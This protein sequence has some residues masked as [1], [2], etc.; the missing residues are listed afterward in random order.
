MRKVLLCTFLFVSLFS[1]SA[2]A[3]I[4]LNKDSSLVF[5]GYADAYYAYYTDSVGTANFQKFPTVSPRSNSFGLNI[6]MFNLKYNA[7]KVHATIGIHYGDIPLSTWSSAYNFIQ[8]AYA[9]VRL[10]KK[11]WLDAG[12]FRTHTGAEGLMPKENITSSVT[13]ATY[14]EP[15]YEAGMRLSIKP[16]DKF[17]LDLYVLNGYN[18]YEENNNK[19][20]VG[21]LATYAFSDHFNIGYSDYFG[22]DAVS[23]SAVSKFRTFNNLFVNYEK[24]KWKIQLAADLITQKHSDT[25]SIKTAQ[26]ADGFATVRYKAC[27]KT[28]VYARGEF[29]KDDSGFLGGSFTDNKNKTTG[30]KL[31]GI[32]AG[33]EYRPTDQAYIRLEARKLQCN[34]AEEIFRWNGADKN[35]RSEIMFHMGYY[36]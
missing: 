18:I 25:V 31:W 24:N 11:I 2:A 17:S 27:T 7:E 4:F 1:F 29:F 21:V 3:Q 5:S 35:Y 26:V 30:I 6:A 12:F 13:V 34:N 15:Y 10:S 33:V 19:K 16:T 20:S 28:S 14:N 36:F 22:D 9:G 23:G 8:E 32:T